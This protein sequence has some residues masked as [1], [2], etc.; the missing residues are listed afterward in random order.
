MSTICA[1]LPVAYTLIKV[2]KERSQKGSRK[3]YGSDYTPRITATNDLGSVESSGYKVECSKSKTL[4]VG[5]SQD[6][7]NSGPVKVKTEVSI[8]TA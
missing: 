4:S 6:L 8:T 2:Q 1:C 3:S 7:E 5:S